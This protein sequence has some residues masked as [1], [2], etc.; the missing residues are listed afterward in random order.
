MPANGRAADRRGRRELALACGLTAIGGLLMLVAAGRPWA[1]AVITQQ[2]LPPRR[3][4]VTGADLSG[5]VRAVA[6][7]GL[8]GV[9]A[10]V[11]LRRRG[12]A[13]V[14]LLLALAGI[15]AVYAFGLAAPDGVRR[16]P[17]VAAQRDTGAQV[18]VSGRTG[19]PYV[20]LAGGI[21]VSVAGGLTLVRGRSW[22]G[23]G[24][25]YEGPAARPGPVDPWTALD[26][27]EDPTLRS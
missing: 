4:A 17:A 19:W 26:R 24:G 14:G 12:R 3:L 6:L 9:A 23:L 22:P 20:Y 7:V 1:S 27:G 10:L 5:G 2:P 13:V 18:S 21:A 16:S 8:A 15:A 11:A 25:R